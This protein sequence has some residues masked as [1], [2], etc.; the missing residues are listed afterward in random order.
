M[1]V[2][3]A[4]TIN[5]QPISKGKRVLLYLADFFLV[6]IL[7]F[8]FFNA[9]VIPVGNLITNYSG[10]KNESGAAAKRQY[11]ILYEQKVMLHENVNDI[12]QYDSN[13]EFT[14]FCYLSYYSFN[15][16]DSI[17]GHPQ[18][19]HKEENEV[20]K[21][22]FFEIK[23]D[24]SSYLDILQSFN[25]ECNYFDI[26][27]ETITLKDD[28]KTNI[29]LSFFSPDDMSVD[30]KTM[31]TNLQ[32]FF[33]KAY[34]EVFKDIEKNDLINNG[35]SYL[36]NKKIVSDLETYYQWQLVISSLIAYV[37]A[38][39]VYFLLLPLF[40]ENHRT[41]AMMML[42]RT[43]I[44]T[45]S[46]F[47]LDKVEGITNSVFMLA[48]NLPIVFFMPMTCVTFSYLFNIP[49]LLAFLF[50][51]LLLILASLIFML[52][53]SYNKTLCDFMLR[54]VIITNDDLDEIYRAKG[55]DI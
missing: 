17:A 2:E 46:L 21:H 19:G 3:A 9:L 37:I 23:N 48:F 44:G 20:V 42:K 38:I 6:F 47:T 40:N 7:T 24:K 15:E 28:I 54:S 10:R 53:S 4:K 30:G 55:Y 8:V 34:A 22:Y 16:T 32:N 52:I 18:Y 39:V 5:I 12:Y 43:R 26:N 45:N 14:R 31:L 27:N 41:L 49:A 25:K 29:K 35:S 36:A 1:E 13:V 33:M 51:G 11:D 50:M